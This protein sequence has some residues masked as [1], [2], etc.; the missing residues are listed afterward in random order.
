MPILS[1]NAFE[2]GGWQK[3]FAFAARRYCDSAAPSEMLHA[4]SRAILKAPRARDYPDLMTFGYFCRKANVERALAAHGDLGQ[5]QGWGTVVHIAPSNIPMNF[6]FSWAMGLLSGNSNIVRLPSRS[7]PQIDLF[8][9]L[10]EQV[11]EADAPWLAREVALVQS[12]RMSVMLD[13]LIA[14]AQGLV[15]WGAD[16]TV[17]RFRALPKQPRAAEVYFPNRLSSVVIAADAV[18]AADEPGLDALALGFFNDTYLV[19]QNACSSPSVVF[20]QG[21]AAEISAAQARL[22]PALSKLLDARYA[23]PP[24]ARMDRMLDVMRLV[25]DQDGPATLEQ[26]HRDLWR[27]SGGAP[28]AAA[29]RFGTFLEIPIRAPG[30]IASYLRGNEQTL[31]CFGFP[32]EVVFEALKAQNQSVD[33]IVPIGRALDMKLNWDG[34]DMITR[35]SRRVD[36]G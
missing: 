32:E 5:R 29:L 22:W 36:V 27:L 3:D 15:V 19:D 4:L 23:L 9:S 30:E 14:Q 18:L 1:A 7:A 10:L 25:Q 34:Q 33:R 16:A 20:W 26:S 31:S 35:L 11:M 28:E 2:A 6:A 13:T 24:V 17:A 21:A 8:V 12:S